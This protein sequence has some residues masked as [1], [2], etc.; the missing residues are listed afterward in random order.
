MS[1]RASLDGTEHLASPAFDPRTVQ[2]LAIRYNDCDMLAAV[3]KEICLRK[4]AFTEHGG[5]AVETDRAASGQKLPCLSVLCY[6]LTE[7][8][9]ILVV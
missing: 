4:M 2:L 5:S 6:S 8:M 7:G 1:L 9:D 3:R